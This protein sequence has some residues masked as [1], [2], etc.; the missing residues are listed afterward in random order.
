MMSMTCLTRIVL[1]RTGSYRGSS[2]KGN[3]P[4]AWSV[5][6]G[7]GSCLDKNIPL[8]ASIPASMETSPSRPPAAMVLRY[9]LKANY[10]V[11]E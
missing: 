8:V 5:H 10:L 7:N 3:L 6:D 9:M 1:S 4:D 11:S 2:K